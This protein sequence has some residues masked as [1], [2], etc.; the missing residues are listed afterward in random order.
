M[1]KIQIA[2]LLLLISLFMGCLSTK[3]VT[4]EADP[5]FLGDFN[6]IQLENFIAGR[7]SMGQLKPLE[8]EAYFVPRNNNLELYF[9]D[10]MNKYALILSYEARQAIEKAGQQYLIAYEE[11][12]LVQEKPTEKN[13]TEFAEA[14]LAWGV[15]GLAR[16]GSTK[17]YTN[18]EFLE[19]G[20]PYFR[21][22]VKQ[23]NDKN[24]SS[25]LSPRVEIY[26]SPALLRTFLENTQQ[27][28]FLS[29]IEEMNQQFA[30]GF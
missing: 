19:K 14:S 17:I 29:Q 3:S 28:V 18:H 12:T 6:P 21:I 10:G 8:I 16:S 23:T 11:G 27:E 26:F 25:T 20:R 24:D 5:N 22:T 1:K 7:Y 9:R 15:T 13:A 4:K 30:D 2:C